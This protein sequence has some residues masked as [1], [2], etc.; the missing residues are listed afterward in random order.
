M[1]ASGSGGNQMVAAG[2]NK[3][4][5]CQPSSQDLNFRSYQSVHT[6]VGIPIFTPAIFIIGYLS[7]CIRGL[8]VDL[9]R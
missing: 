2:L 4:E 1:N 7:V 3:E 5:R 8:P 6:H 9:Y